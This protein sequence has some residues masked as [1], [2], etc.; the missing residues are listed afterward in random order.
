MRRRVLGIAVHGSTGT[1]FTGS[2]VEPEFGVNFLW[3]KLAEER[4]TILPGGTIADGSARSRSTL[5][6]F[7]KESGLVLAP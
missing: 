4:L 5:E 6:R 2:T 3:Q 1:G 7:A